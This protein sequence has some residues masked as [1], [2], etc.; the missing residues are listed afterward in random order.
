MTRGSVKA[1]VVLSSIHLGR[2]KVYPSY[3]ECALLVYPAIHLPMWVGRWRIR[4]DE[5]V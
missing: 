2:E 4:E 1:L 3:V 5:P